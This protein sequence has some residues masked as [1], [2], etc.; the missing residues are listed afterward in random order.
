[1]ATQ[2][3]EIGLSQPPQIHAL[4][5]K[6]INRIAAGEV[7]QK[8]SSAVK[9][10]LENSLDAGSTQI[11]LVVRDGGLKFLQIT[12]N[13]HGVRAADLPLLCQRHTTS[14]L[15]AFEDLE[16]VET[17]GFRGEALC[18]ISF[19]SHMT[20]TTMTRGANVGLRASYR[21]G[22][23]VESEPKWCAA[24]PGTT[25]TVEDL[26]Y[27]SITR[28]KSFKNVSEEH[29]RILDVVGR[30]AVFRHE[31]AFSV[32][33]QGEAR[34]DLGAPGQ[35]S[36][37]DR[38]GTVFGT[39]VS[40]GLLSMAMNKGSMEENQIDSG[41]AFELKG[42]ISGVDYSGKKTILVLFINGRLVESSQFKRAVEAVY[43]S[44]L[45]RA[46]KPFVYV[47]MKMPT[48]HVDVNVHPT[49]RQVEF[50]YQDEIIG[51]ITEQ[52][53]EILVG[54]NHSRTFATQR[55]SGGFVSDSQTKLGDGSVTEKG[56]GSQREKAGGDHKLIRTD[57]RL[58]TMD[59]FVQ[60]H[61]NRTA[62]VESAKMLG[63]ISRRQSTVRSLSLPEETR[64]PPSEGRAKR[65]KCEPSSVED[66][67]EDLMDGIDEGVHG[68]VLQILNEHTFVGM[69]DET[70]AFIQHKTGLYFAD[71]T[72]LS[73][74]MFYQQL[75]RRFRN[76]ESV[77]IDPPPSIQALAVLALDVLEAKG[78]L[79][80]SNG[81]KNEIAE[82]IAEILVQ[83]RDKLREWFSFVVTENGCIAGIPGVLDRYSPD[84]NRL[85]EF[86]VRL[87]RDVEW[88]DELI[89]VD[90]VAKLV[91]DF[92][93]IKAPIGKKQKE[94]EKEGKGVGVLCSN[95]WM[96]QHI[97]FQ[98]MRSLVNPPRC[99]ATD[100]SLVQVATLENL[101]KVFER[102]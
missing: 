71:V 53:Q 9:E 62:A 17:L 40:K 12:D 101:Y 8:P 10:L 69:A 60:H 38:I 55:L 20:V 54:S 64:G 84:M 25:I 52:I 16:T 83:N 18:S 96:I 61:P 42:Y 102:C 78:E 21:D 49:K 94:G 6:V 72:V 14:K 77:A 41:L 37:S 15:Q 36:Q 98:A 67:V 33:R 65:K 75:I 24:T 43:T 51:A 44:V 56:K 88:R 70:L 19:V 68:G 31:V 34:V 2:G 23:M 87:G 32:K 46:T 5:E 81:S 97:V 30:Y 35:A 13:G 91:A 59:A 50:L 73:R 45:P 92:Y 80:D 74:D 85:P 7:I 89:A 57:H 29:A 48:R 90:L 3:T 66:V 63:A 28:K 76:L 27:N 47:Q 22:E 58:M 26:F 86:L 95:D 82:T 99:R 11:T 79:N 93:S 1:M 100:G 39:T 4:D